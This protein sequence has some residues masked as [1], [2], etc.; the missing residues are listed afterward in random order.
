VEIVLQVDAPPWVDVDRVELVRRGE[1]I[2]TWAAPFPKSPH[3]FETRLRRSLAKG[4]WILAL[5]RG[6]KPMS[7][8]YRPNARPFAFTNPVWVE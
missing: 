2:G 7:Y 5:A 6:S 1:V 3:R 8:L 4:D